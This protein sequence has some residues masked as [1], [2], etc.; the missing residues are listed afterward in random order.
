MQRKSPLEDLA[1]VLLRK[2][3]G[4]LHVGATVETGRSL[5]GCRRRG[6]N[7]WVRKIPWRRKWQPIPIFLPGKSHEQRSLV[8]LAKSH[9]RRGA[10]SVSAERKVTPKVKNWHEVVHPLLPRGILLLCKPLTL[11]CILYTLHSISLLPPFC[12]VN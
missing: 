11:G 12:G 8:G 1:T 7:P 4:F 6:F 3:L 5:G 2:L 10:H 9:T